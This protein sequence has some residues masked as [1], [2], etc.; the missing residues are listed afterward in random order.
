MGVNRSARTLT[1]YV[2]GIRR[3]ILNAPAGHPWNLWQ[4]MT[5]DHPLVAGSN[6]I[7]V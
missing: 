3:S 1:I 4:E 7:M 5:I 6:I 2:N